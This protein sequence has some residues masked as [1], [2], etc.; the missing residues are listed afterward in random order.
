MA[1]KKDV[2]ASHTYAYY[3]EKLRL[4]KSHY[5]LFLRIRYKITQLRLI[6]DELFS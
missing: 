5:S 2:S 6:L 3:F 1:Y 4:Y